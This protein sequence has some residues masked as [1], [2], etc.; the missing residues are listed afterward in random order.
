MREKG[1]FNEPQQASDACQSENGQRLRAVQ[2][3]ERA[4]HPSPGK[5]AGHKQVMEARVT[6][7][8]QRQYLESL[9]SLVGGGMVNG[10]RVGFETS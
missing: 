2:K 1:K 6:N 3:T 5:R 7:D 8:V 4:F 10:R 9:R